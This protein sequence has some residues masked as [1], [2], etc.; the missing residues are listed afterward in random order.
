MIY[1][2]LIVALQ[3]K[4]PDP[5]PEVIAALLAVDDRYAAIAQTLKIPSGY[6]VTSPFLQPEPLADVVFWMD[7][8]LR[9][10]LHKTADAPWRGIRY[11][12]Y[13]AIRYDRRL[14][15]GDAMRYQDLLGAASLLYRHGTPE[16]VGDRAAARA[17]LVALVHA[18][19]K[20]PNPGETNIVD[21]LKSL[22]LPSGRK[23]WYGSL[24]MGMMLGPD[25]NIISTSDWHRRF[26]VFTDGR[27]SYLEWLVQD[28][29]L[30]RP[31]GGARGE[32]SAESGRRILRF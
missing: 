14:A 6:R 1:N 30:P 24:T 31:T 10:A 28:S 27:T 23:L 25:R 18:T 11:P 2:L 22:D 7:R 26:T 13:D 20:H 15:S 9:P 17:K 19:L 21:Y 32:A 12:R 3:A 16:L 5:D 8:V 29:T 4:N